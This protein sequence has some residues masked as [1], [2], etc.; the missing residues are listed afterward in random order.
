MSVWQLVRGR[1]LI[2]SL[3]AQRN[4]FIAR[5]SAFQPIRSLSGRPTVFMQRDFVDI[6]PGVFNAMMTEE[7]L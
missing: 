4:H 5:G 2:A 3:S 7:A 6:R 1:G